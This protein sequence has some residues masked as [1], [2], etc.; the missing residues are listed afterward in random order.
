M[1]NDNIKAQQDKL[2]SAQDKSV[3]PKIKSLVADKIKG[4]TSPVKK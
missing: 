4:L 3:N 1:P 2:K